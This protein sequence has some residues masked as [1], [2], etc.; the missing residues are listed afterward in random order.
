MANLPQ[1]GAY[2]EER[3]NTPSDELDAELERLNQEFS[4][5]ADKPAFQ[6]RGLVSIAASL[7]EHQV[8][9]FR[10]HLTRDR[11]VT[12]KFGRG[13]A[14]TEVK[15]VELIDHQNRKDIAMAEIPRSRIE[16]I[17]INSRA[18]AVCVED[19]DVILLE[20]TTAVR[21]FEAESQDTDLQT[22][23]HL[24]G[25][26]VDD[27]YTEGKEKARKRRRTNATEVEIHE[28]ARAKMTKKAVKRGLIQCPR[29]LHVKASFYAPPQP[30]LVLDEWRMF[31]LADFRWPEDDVLLVF[32]ID[33]ML[34]CCKEG[35]EY[36]AGAFPAKT[37]PA[38]PEA[39]MA[40]KATSAESD[41]MATP[42]NGVPGPTTSSLSLLQQKMDVCRRADEPLVEDW[43][44]ALK[45]RMP[46]SPSASSDPTGGTNER[47]STLLFGDDVLLY[48]D[49]TCI[50]TRSNSN[51][52]AHYR[53]LHFTY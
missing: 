24:R 47:S 36:D 15:I 8:D 43:R 4:V 21:D 27:S 50:L 9:K 49:H 23:A 5:E 33:A 52:H 41:S 39:T 53:M 31:Y 3:S 51:P 45:V 17:A 40:D 29:R 34:K 22:L 48:V 44:R 16:N 1:L 18:L 32:D 38:T 19:A 10:F 25:I 37:L 30:M 28:E 2:G 26:D 42:A 14:Y 13:T 7:E 46:L 35:H 20:Q 11:Y 6:L 12:A